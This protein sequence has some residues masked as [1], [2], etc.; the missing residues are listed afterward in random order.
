MTAVES[1]KRLASETPVSLFIPYSHHVTDTII[2]TKNAEYLSVWKIDGRSHQSASEEDIFQWTKELNNTLRG[3]ASANLSLWTHIVRRR[4]YEYPD[5]TFD[6]MFCYQLDEK[7]RQSF[8]GYN[9]MVNDLY[10]TIV[11][12]PIADKV[13]SFFLSMNVKRSIKKRCGKN[14]VLKLLMISTVP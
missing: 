14:H 4:V 2:S 3:I 9:L 6:K 1:S 10:L 11:F 5:S 7:Y 8:T 12:Q 13:M